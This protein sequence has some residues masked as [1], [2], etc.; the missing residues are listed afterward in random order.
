MR[1]LPDRLLEAVLFAD[2]ATD[3]TP[4]HLGEV[5]HKRLAIARLGLSEARRHLRAGR[6]DDAGVLLDKV[7]EDLHLL[8]RRLTSEAQP[9]N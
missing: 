2:P 1:L 7:E 4:T 8:Q 6:S 9:V 3:G 5:V